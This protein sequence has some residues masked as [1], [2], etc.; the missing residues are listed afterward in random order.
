MTIELAAELLGR[1]RVVRFAANAGRQIG[2]LAS[3]L[4][5]V[6][7][8]A[9]SAPWRRFTFEINPVKSR[10]EDVVAVDGLLVI[11]AA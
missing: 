2:P 10:T 11:D 4:A 7:E 1:L 6:S 5:S 8:L 3:F 9:A